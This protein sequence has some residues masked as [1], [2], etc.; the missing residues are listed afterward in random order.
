[1]MEA[2]RSSLKSV[3]TGATRRNIPEESILQC[4]TCLP[5][6]LG[7]EWTESEVLKLDSVF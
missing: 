5:T 2:I 1:M 3:L 7:S 6:C 4:G